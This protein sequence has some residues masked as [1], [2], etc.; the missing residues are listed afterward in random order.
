MERFII[1]AKHIDRMS[2]AE[3][4]KYLEGPILVRFDDGDVLTTGREIIFSRY[5]WELRRNYP[6]VR[7]SKHHQLRSV[8]GEMGYINN[9]THTQLL[10]NMLFDI[11]D[12][13]GKNP[14]TKMA[15]VDELA[16]NVY[17]ISNQI[18]NDFSTKIPEYVT[19]IDF[20]HFL[21]IAQYQAIRDVMLNIEPN[22]K[23]IANAHAV[24]KNALMTHTELS[25]NPL[26]IAARAKA[27]RDEQLLQ[28]IGP[29]IS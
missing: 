19:S 25:H 22:E 5:I 3:C 29:R 23:S 28:C 26:T 12:V 15:L 16:R 2:I 24:I 7:L 14:D 13:Y 8:T 17:R 4:W 20:T 6:N 11:V 1:P 9:G 18:Y 10:G 21:E 27:V